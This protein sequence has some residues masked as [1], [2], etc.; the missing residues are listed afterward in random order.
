MTESGAR[1]LEQIEQ[2]LLVDDP[3]FIARF[4]QATQRLTASSPQSPPGPIVVAVDGTLS[5]LQA[6]HWAASRARTSGADIRIVHAFRWRSWPTDYG[7]SELD[8]LSQQGAGED[9]C[10][11]AVDLASAVAPASRI[12]GRLVAGSPGPAIVEAARGAAMLVHGGSSLRWLP[13]VL[14]TSTLLHVLDR[15]RCTVAMLPDARRAP[16]MLTERARVCVGVD[17]G[18][19]DL[20]ALTE[21]VHIAAAD[22]LEMLVVCASGSERTTGTALASVLVH[23]AVT[24]ERMTA[25]EGLVDTLVRLAPSA[26]AVVCDRGQLRLQWPWLGSCG[27][28]LLRDAGC[29]VLL[30]RAAAN[31][32]G[33]RR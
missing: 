23:R 33:D 16:P 4:R 25:R 6:V 30:K 9:I 22:G 10:A 11:S 13:T 7:A 32:L 24:V 31:R 8:D 1:D 21:A 26:R 27:R 20:P 14:R 2:A 5:S 19:G 18:P 17:G 29:P 12:S 3:H 15:T 28:R